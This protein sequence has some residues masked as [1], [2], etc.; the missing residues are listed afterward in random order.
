MS[1]DTKYGDR[2]DDGHWENDEDEPD[3]TSPADIKRHEVD[4]ILTTDPHEQDGYGR[5]KYTAHVSHRHDDS[6][7]VLYATEHRWKSNY[8]RNVEDIDWHDVPGA[9]QKQVAAVV[10]CDG[11]RD[12]HPGTRVVGEDGRSTWTEPRDDAQTVD[13]T[14]PNCGVEGEGADV[15]AHDQLYCPGSKCPIVTFREGADGD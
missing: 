9:V 3:P 6:P 8:W 11:R 7:I 12:L 4:V 10:D 15:L 1:D 2:I 5:E 14:C 13:A